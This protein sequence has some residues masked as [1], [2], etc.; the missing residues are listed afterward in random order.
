MEE[1]FIN[2]NGGY[3]IRDESERT[4]DINGSCSGGEI[5]VEAVEE[6]SSDDATIER[7]RASNERKRLDMNARQP[8]MVNIRNMA[9]LL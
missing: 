5:E 9:L 3:T 7:L 4:C 6:A 8:G 2:R 1:F